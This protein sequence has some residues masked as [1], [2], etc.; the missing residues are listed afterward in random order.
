MTT[1]HKLVDLKTYLIKLIPL[2]RTPAGDLKNIPV[3]V[4]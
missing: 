4:Q 2:A 1:K 3:I